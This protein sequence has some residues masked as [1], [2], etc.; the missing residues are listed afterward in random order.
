MQE[1]DYLKE[2]LYLK[3]PFNGNRQRQ[4]HTLAHHCCWRETVGTHG[5][6]DR[7][8]NCAP[9]FDDSLSMETGEK[10]ICN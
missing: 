10:T 1:K 6:E 3:K 9:R 7:L 8:G 4:L 2:L 5:A